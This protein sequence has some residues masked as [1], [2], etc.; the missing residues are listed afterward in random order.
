MEK[1]PSK[2]KKDS[3]RGPTLADALRTIS[4]LKDINREQVNRL[5]DQTLLEKLNKDQREE[6]E[7]LRGVI[8]QQDKVIE[9]LKERLRKYEPA[10]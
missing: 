3:R 4:S 6:I 5:R 7:D 9:Q 10:P 2:L 8:K 1:P